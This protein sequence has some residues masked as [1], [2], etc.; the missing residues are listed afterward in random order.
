MKGARYLLLLACCLAGPAGAFPVDIDVNLE[1]LEVEII[2]VRIDEAVVLRV[3]NFEAGEIRCD[4]EFHNG[5]EVARQ[6]KVTVESGQDRIVRWA[7]SRQVVRVKVGGRCWR[8]DEAH[9]AA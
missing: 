3:R 6:R 7:P 8:I 4:F 9:A 1:G 2:R 5:P